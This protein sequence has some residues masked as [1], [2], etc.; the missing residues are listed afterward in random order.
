MTY[1][2]KTISLRKLYWNTFK[3]F[4]LA[5]FLLLIIIF[6]MTRVFTISEMYAPFVLLSMSVCI[7]FFVIPNIEEKIAERAI[8]KLNSKKITIKNRV[9]SIEKIKKIRV[10]SRCFFARHPLLKIYFTDKTSYQIRASS[11]YEIHFEKM[12]LHLQAIL[13]ERR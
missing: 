6:G 12:I 8:V 9:F 5:I 3:Y 4:C 10:T 11:N 13:N 1:Q 2:F 7:A